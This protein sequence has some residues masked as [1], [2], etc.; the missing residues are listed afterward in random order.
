MKAEGAGVQFSIILRADGLNPANGLITTPGSACSIIGPDWKL[1][2][3]RARSVFPDALLRVIGDRLQRESLV[4][5]REFGPL[6]SAVYV[7][8]IG[9]FHLPDRLQGA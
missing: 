1:S 7:Q 2:R 6:L 3:P 4:R 9:R 8:V 5:A